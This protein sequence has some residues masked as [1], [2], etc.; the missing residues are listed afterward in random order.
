M[1]KAGSPVFAS[2]MGRLNGWCL[3]GRQVGARRHADELAETGDYDRSFVAQ[4]GHDAA[5][6]ETQ[7]AS[8]MSSRHC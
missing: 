6:T 8:P 7:L 4:L 5:F 3:A 1:T 2:V